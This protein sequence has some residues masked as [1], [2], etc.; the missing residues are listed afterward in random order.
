M[1]IVGKT[2]QLGN[3]VPL[4]LPIDKPAKAG[5]IV[6]YDDQYY[7]VYNAG[8]RL[9]FWNVTQKW[10]SEIQQY[11]PGGSAMDVVGGGW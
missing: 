7:R 1:K 9:A 6:Q 11:V 8:N 3:I 10:E 5:D 2:T 4:E